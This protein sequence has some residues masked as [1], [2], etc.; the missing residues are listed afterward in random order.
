MTVGILGAAPQGRPSTA[1]L[2]A[3]R[4]LAGAARK[5][6]RGRTPRA[7]GGGTTITTDTAAAAAGRGVGAPSEG[8]GRLGWRWGVV[9]AISRSEATRVK[10]TVRVNLLS[11][12]SRAEGA[13][14]GG[15]SE[16]WGAAQAGTTA[17]AGTPRPGRDRRGGRKSRGLVA[18]E[19]G[20]G[21]ARRV[22]ASTRRGGGTTR[23]R[24]DRAR[25]LAG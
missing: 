24:G 20:R 22:L 6:Q 21:G 18:A 23:R 12:R 2:G 16:P 17:T 7:V 10:K 4:R 5:G 14:T 25:V 9:A 13:T 8:T 11:L 1:A 15:R 19:Q 3:G